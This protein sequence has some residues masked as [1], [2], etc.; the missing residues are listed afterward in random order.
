MSDQGRSSAGEKPTFAQIAE[1]AEIARE[2]MAEYVRIVDDFIAASGMSVTRFGWDFNGD[3]DYR[4][5][6]RKGRHSRLD[7]CMKVLAKIEAHC[8]TVIGNG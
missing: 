2:A 3:P 6:L 7:T 8:K 1:D 5:K 4:A